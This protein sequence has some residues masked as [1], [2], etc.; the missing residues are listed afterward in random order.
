M[1]TWVSQL[2]YWLFTLDKYLTQVVYAKSWLFG[3]DIV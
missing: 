1:S 3:K 2:V